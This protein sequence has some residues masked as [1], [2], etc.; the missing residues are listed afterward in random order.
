MYRIVVLVFVLDCIVVFVFGL[1]W[2]MQTSQ[3]EL[4]ANGSSWTDNGEQ[5]DE[6]TAIA[7][8]VDARTVIERLQHEVDPLS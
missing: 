5:S 7:A 2:T 1:D 6:T 8:S 4:D 3:P